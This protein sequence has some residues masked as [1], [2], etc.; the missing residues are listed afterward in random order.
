[1][2]LRNEL[3]TENLL[4]IHEQSKRIFNNCLNCS[5]TWPTRFTVT[6]LPTRR[7]ECPSCRSRK[8]SLNRA[9]F[10]PFTIAE[11]W[12]LPTLTEEAKAWIE[13]VTINVKEKGAN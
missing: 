3:L 12:T 6:H 8:T 5:F 13:K 9:L 2:D 11:F 7:L 10:G 4:Q 1:M